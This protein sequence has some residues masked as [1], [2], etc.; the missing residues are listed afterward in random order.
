[1]A[2]TH[3]SIASL[4]SSISAAAAATDEAKLAAIS[5]N[6][7]NTP[8]SRA[9]S[10]IEAEDGYAHE[11]TMIVAFYND[12]VAFIKSLL[13][14]AV[15]KKILSFH[16][17]EK[18]LVKSVAAV[19]GRQCL[20]VIGDGVIHQSNSRSDL[21]FVADTIIFNASRHESGEVHPGA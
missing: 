1:M 5:S 13:A 18:I 16:F 19:Q 12:Q 14:Q 2:A 15:A 9:K 11:D 6:S 17:V 8:G 20:W 3:S 7:K 4:S 21:G 10:K